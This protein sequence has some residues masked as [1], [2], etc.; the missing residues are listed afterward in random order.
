[1]KKYNDIKADIYFPGNS[2]IQRWDVQHLFQTKDTEFVKWDLT[3]EKSSMP[4]NLKEHLLEFYKDS[5]SSLSQIKKLNHINKYNLPTKSYN[6]T[7]KNNHYKNEFKRMYIELTQRSWIHCTNETICRYSGA[8]DIDFGDD[9]ITYK[10][11]DQLWNIKTV[12]ESYETFY[13]YYKKIC[14]Q[15]CW[16]RIPLPKISKDLDLKIVLTNSITKK[17]DSIK[18]NKPL[19]VCQNQSNTSLWSYASWYFD[20]FINWAMYIIT[21]YLNKRM[22]GRSASRIV[23]DE[24]WKKYLFVERIYTL[25]SVS[26]QRTDIIWWL[27]KELSKHYNV[28]TSNIITVWRENDYEFI[29]KNLDWVKY[30][31]L[32][33]WIFRWPKRELLKSFP[34][35]YYKDSV[36]FT[37]SDDAGKTYYDLISP[38]KDIQDKFTNE[39]SWLPNGAAIFLIN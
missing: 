10:V 27:F 24:S 35:S 33:K 38:Q 3:Q 9:Y 8:Q 30:K 31:R 15:E 37:V 18:L 14:T 12:K 7:V 6:L 28:L 34:T 17:L 39:W 23:Y 4:K 11:Y 13:K 26:Q 2:S 21:I 1:M 5:Q 29:L 16:S 20:Y 25:D 19:G 22:I 32:R 36:V